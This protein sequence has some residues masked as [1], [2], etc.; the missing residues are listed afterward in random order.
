MSEQQKN[1]SSSKQQCGNRLNV[2]GI[3]LG[4]IAIVITLGTLFLTVE[5]RLEQNKLQLLPVTLP[6]LIKNTTNSTIHS[7]LATVDAQLDK[8]NKAIASLQQALAKSHGPLQLANAKTLISLAQLD[9]ENGSQTKVATALLKLAKEKL[10]PT[11]D[12]A[13]IGSI[14]DDLKSLEKQ[15]GS[16][17][18]ELLASLQQ[19]SLLATQ[20]DAIAP[21]R[22]EL[23][24]TSHEKHWYARSWKNLKSLFIIQRIS[25]DNQKL[26]SP[27]QAQLVKASIEL[28]L[29][30]ASWALTQNNKNLYENSLNHA[31]KLVMEGFKKNSALENIANLL[32]KLTMADVGKSARSLLSYQLITN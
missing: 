14:N 30:L 25:S 19:V 7:A 9:I 18:L 1:K 15:R 16:S 10:N 4:S 8:Q 24:T 21:Q 20:L 32:G 3:V 2:T 29:N 17:R 27:D 22:K 31:S 23:N 13:L 5:N 12:S 26:L 28:Q 11:Q 6:S